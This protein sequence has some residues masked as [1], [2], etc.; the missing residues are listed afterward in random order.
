MRATSMSDMTNVCTPVGGPAKIKL[1]DKRIANI[2]KI[3][4]TP[5]IPTTSSWQMARL[6]RLFLYSM[7][8]SGSNPPEYSPPS[9]IA[10]FSEVSGCVLVPSASCTQADARDKAA[11]S[12]ASI[13]W[14][15]R[16]CW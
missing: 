11:I 9:G 6:F 5:N 14:P 16:C 2:M 1:R 4:Q 3:Q 8:F 15:H 7:T 12:C 10:E 13:E